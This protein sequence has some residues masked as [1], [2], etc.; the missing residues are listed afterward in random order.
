[1]GQ[2]QSSGKQGI[3]GIEGPIG[4]IGLTGPNGPSGP[5]GPKGST[6]P[7][8][9]IGPIGP[10]STWNDF[11]PSEKGSFVENIS[12]D[13]YYRN[14]VANL[15]INNNVFSQSIKTAMAKDPVLKE[16]VKTALVTTLK[17]DQSFKD[18]VKGEKG[19]PGSPGGINEENKKNLIW[20]ADGTC[21]NDGTGVSLT[22]GWKNGADTTSSEISNDVGTYKKLMVVGNKSAGGEREVGVWDNLS[23]AKQTTTQSL[24]IGDWVIK[25]HPYGLGFYH[26][27]DER[28][29]AVIATN[30]DIWEDKNKRWLSNAVDTQKVYHVKAQDNVNASGFNY[31]SKTDLWSGNRGSTATFSKEKGNWQK[32]KFEL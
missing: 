15:L 11:S 10:R 12:N 1:M 14:A 16:A 13:A 28:A 17:A 6:G 24:K 8:G 19:A 27:A 32:F 30:G 31:L 25:S 22:Q 26:K 23:V 29:K 3:Q 5:P 20:C 4:P 7:K 18:S 2:T 21:R 9:D